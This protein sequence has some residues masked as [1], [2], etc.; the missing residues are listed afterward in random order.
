MGFNETY[1]GDT[2]GAQSGIGDLQV[3]WNQAI[4]Q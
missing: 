4:P 2:S 1:L 3:A